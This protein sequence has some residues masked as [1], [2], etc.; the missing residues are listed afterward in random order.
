LKGF[1]VIGLNEV[2][3]PLHLFSDR[4]QAKVLGETTDMAWLFAP[5]EHRWWRDHFGNGILS[6]LPVTNWQRIPLADTRRKGH[7]NV[8]IAVIPMRGQKLHVLITHLT[9]R[10]TRKDQLKTVFE[11]FLDIDPPVVLMG[12]LNTFPTDPQIGSLLSTP[13]VVEPLNDVL[14]N[15]APTRRV[16]WIYVRGLEVVDAGIIDRGASDHPCV[17]A[18]LR[19]SPPPPR[20]STVNKPG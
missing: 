18:E 15:Q 8:V 16:D 20:D 9:R 4:D 10:K 6:N 17:W 12:D 11:M 5:T 14:G 13:G 2:H 3:G 19:L 7:R 1:D